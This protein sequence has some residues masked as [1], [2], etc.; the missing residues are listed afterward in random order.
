MNELL[1]NL[2]VVSFEP[3]EGSAEDC[4]VDGVGFV[5][6]PLVFLLEINSVLLG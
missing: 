4:P 1:N 6:C 2:F 3:A 5:V